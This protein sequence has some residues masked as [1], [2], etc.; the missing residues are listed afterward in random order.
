MTDREFTNDFKYIMQD[1]YK[2]Y[3][4]AK[5]T[6]KEILESEETYARFKAVCRQ[7]L[8][9]EVDQDTTIESHLYYLAAE[10]KAAEVYRL[11]GARVKLSVPAVKKGLLGREQR[12][13]REEI[14]KI[15]DLLMLSARQKQFRGIILSE[16]QIPK[17]KLREFAI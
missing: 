5:C 6:Y 12:V 2:L 9:T 3:F 1:L 16:V 4:G 8:I 7:C 11:L 15:E 14:W 10:D 13:F 17:L